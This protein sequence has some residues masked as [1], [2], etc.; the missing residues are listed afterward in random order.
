LVTAYITFA[1]EAGMRLPPKPP[2]P[3][4]LAKLLATAGYAPLAV[5]LVPHADAVPLA[6]MIRGTLEWLLD[7]ATLEQ[8]FR[9]H[10][11]QQYTRELTLHALVRLVIQVAAGIRASVFAAF[12]ADQALPEPTITTTYQA[13]YGKLGRLQPAVSEAVVRR[14]AERCGR[15]LTLLPQARHEPRPGYRMRVLDGNVLA[16]SEHRLTPLRRWLNACLPGKS[17]VVYEPGSGLVTDVVLCEDAYT[18]ERALVTQILPRVEA[19]D[20]FVADRNFC[21]TRFVFGVSAAGAAAIVRQ[22]RR[23]L[24]CRALDRLRRCGATETGVVYEQSVQATD[25]DSGAVLALRRIEVRLFTETRDGERT[26]AVLTNLPADVAAVEIAEDYLRRWTIEKHFQFLTQS[27]RCELPGLGQ[28]RAALFGFAMALLAANALA[29][30]RG[31]LR[32]AHGAAAEA[33]VSG[34]YLADEIA[35]DYRTLMKY[36]PA[37][38]WYAWRAVPAVALASLLRTLAAQVNL[39]AL[40]RSVRGPKKPRQPK[41]VYDRKHKHYSTA[42]LLNELDE[43]D[44]C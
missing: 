31:G 14:G 24:P 12:K 19:R 5:T 42:R 6:V 20:L 17:L 1:I 27:L 15:L 35:H 9:A 34:Y 13:V 18:Q 10:A 44:T 43:Q 37:E 33:E 26:I 40:T 8:L 39:K 3:D 28:P 2:A 16:G 4:P 30:L 11:P 25:P 41:P 36:V 29:I 38:Q 7:E 22:H 23:T 32:S 21:T